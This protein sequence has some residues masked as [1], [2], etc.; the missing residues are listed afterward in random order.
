[1]AANLLAAA[2]IRQVAGASVSI[3]GMTGRAR[4]SWGIGL[5]LLLILALAAF[6]RIR[7]MGFDSLTFDE[8]W[9]LELSTGRG[10]PHVRMPQDVLIPDAPDVTSL[11]GAPPVTAVWTHMD[12]VVHPPLYCVLLR[13]WRDVFGETD[14]PA[15]AFSVFCSI[16]SIALLFALGAELHDAPTALWACALMAVAPT[17]VLLGQQVREYM[18]VR[19]FALAAAWSIVRTEKRGATIWRSVA[20]CLC[21]LAMML[22]HYF[23]I[24]VCVALAV[25]SIIRL[26]RAALIHSIAAFIVAGA[27]YLLIW[28]PFLYQQRTFFSETG[29]TWL[30]EQIPYHALVSVA[31]ALAIPIRQFTL[32]HDTN[33]AWAAIGAPMIIATAIRIRWRR[34]LL[35][36]CLWLAGS[37]G[38]VLL[39]DLSRTSLHLA[40]IRYTSLAAPA[41]FMIMAALARDLS[42]MMR[43]VIPAA[44][45]ASGVVMSPAA[46]VS[47]QPDSR[48]LGSIVD[49]HGSSEE[50]IVFYNGASPGWFNQIFYLGTCHYS[51]TFPRPIVKLSRPAST[52]LVAQLGGT[53]WLIS[54][55]LDRPIDEILPGAKRAEQHTI[56]NLA[57]LTRVDLPNSSR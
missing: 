46:F 28:G 54:G 34:D 41:I 42:P 55:P 5:A 6:L 26:R 35:L 44:I 32:P 36:W 19:V 16:A 27:I 22:T 40:I 39:I 30:K 24:G 33:L 2:S 50:P 15:Q 49:A 25:F 4:K 11:R 53:A 45:V 38:F 13:L 12:Y 29:D 43:Q 57:I 9:H 52:Q 20:L 48:P 37:I 18:L 3:R 31:R 17:Q 8:Q 1:V 47:E 21:T 10:S 23:A 56:P 51:H 7:R 14:A